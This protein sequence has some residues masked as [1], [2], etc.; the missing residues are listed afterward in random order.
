MSSR[1]SALL[2]TATGPTRTTVTL[3]DDVLALLKQ[4]MRERDVSFKQALNDAIRVGESA[5]AAQ[6]AARLDPPRWKVYDMGVPLV[7]LT[8]ANALLSDMDAEEFMA[9]MGRQA[10]PVAAEPAA[11]GVAESKADPQA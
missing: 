2:G 3:D 9:R 11:Q 8:K 10:V 5:R 6:A 7:D 1:R 4:A